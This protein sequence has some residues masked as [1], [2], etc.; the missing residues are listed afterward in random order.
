MDGIR[1][2]RAGPAFRTLVLAPAQQ[3]ESVLIML[4]CA[5]S[6]AGLRQLPWR[7]AGVSWPS[8]ECVGCTEPLC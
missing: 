2:C 6:D 1:G 3:G 4:P 7:H 8:P 5:F